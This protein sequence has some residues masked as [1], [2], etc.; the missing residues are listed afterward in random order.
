MKTKSLKNLRKNVEKYIQ[1][2]DLGFTAKSIVNGDVYGAYTAID[3]DIA[4]IEYT[5]HEVAHAMTLGRKLSDLPKDIHLSDWIDNMLD[6]MPDFTSDI[7]EI[8]TAVVV[9]LAGVELELWNDPDAIIFA[10]RKNLKKTD[11]RYGNKFY[12]LFE[13]SKNS[14]VSKEK[15]KKLA[16]FIRSLK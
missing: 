14:D 9:F 4:V 13:D 16:E 5:M 15:G 7:I 8:D 6:D 2:E 11:L 3:S 1:N 12:D 10:A